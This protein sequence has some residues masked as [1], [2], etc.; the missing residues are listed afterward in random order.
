[1]VSDTNDNRSKG[2]FKFQKKAKAIFS[3]KLANQ[4][5]P[6]AEIVC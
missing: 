3:G 2:N 1:M 6:Y 5:Q 4:I